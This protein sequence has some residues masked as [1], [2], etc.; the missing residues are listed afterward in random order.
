MPSCRPRETTSSPRSKSASCGPGSTRVPT[1]RKGPTCSIRGWRKPKRTGPF[2]RCALSRFRRVK[3]A[4]WAARRSTDSSL[5]PLSRAASRRRRESS[6]IGSSGASRSTSS[7]CRP[8]SA[9]AR[10]NPRRWPQ[11]DQPQGDRK[12][13]V[14]RLLASPHYG[15]RWGRHWLDVA[16]YADSD[17]YES[18]ADRPHAYHYRDFVIRALNDD[19][20][21]D[22]FLR[23][24]LAGDEIEPDNSAGRR[25]HGLSDGRGHYDPSAHAPGGRAAAQSLQR[26]GRHPL[27]HRHGHARAD[28]RLRPLPRPQVRRDLVARVLPAAGSASTAAIAR[29]RKLPRRRGRDARLPRSGRASRSPRGSLAAATSTTAISRC[30]SAFWTC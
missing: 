11:N 13:L 9:D 16:R 23:W 17:G 20:P 18:D 15:E 2:S 19:L 22:T 21:L 8:T 7:A 28:A 1:G 6:L 4:A 3:D 25:R 10:G 30:S 27:D 24:Q 29:S 5:P 12:Q 14:D 26:A